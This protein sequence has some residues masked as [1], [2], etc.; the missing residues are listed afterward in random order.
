[1]GISLAAEYHSI[2]FFFRENSYTKLGKEGREKVE[3]EE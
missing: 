2:K 1:M 3:G